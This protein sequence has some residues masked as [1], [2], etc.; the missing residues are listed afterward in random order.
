MDFNWALETK[1]DALKISHMRKRLLYSINGISRVLTRYFCVTDIIF[2]FVTR[3]E[4]T[5]VLLW[6]QTF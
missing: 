6:S 4:I 1:L 3:I 5:S 2:L